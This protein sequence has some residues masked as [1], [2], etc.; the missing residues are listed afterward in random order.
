[1]AA[2]L[3]AGPYAAL[4]HLDAAAHWALRSVRSGAIQVTVS[5]RGPEHRAGIR[6]HQ[7]R[8]VHADD[9]AIKDGIPVT[10]V[11]R[12][13]FDSAEMLQMRQLERLF[14]QA[15]RLRLFDLRALDAVCERNPGR[16]ALRPVKTLLAT[17]REPP[18]TRTELE[19]LLVDL[20]R[21]Y[22]I[23]EPAFNVTVA[24]YEVDAWWPGTNRIAELDSYA[25]HSSRTAF[26]NDR[27]RDLELTLAGFEVIRIT[28]RM[29]KGRPAQLAQRIRTFLAAAAPNPT[30][31][32]AHPGE[33]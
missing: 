13:L 4:S 19:R 33:A 22:D 11:A 18:A 25:Y 21:E 23:P 15:E 30:S 29:L 5:A 3:A 24:G 16:R 20:C 10:S 28:H 26:E 7:V 32:V 6:V 8:R 2:V 31:F 17:F 1:M 9:T 14:E 12:T 27:E